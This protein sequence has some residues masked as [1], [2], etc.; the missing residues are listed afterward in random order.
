[1]L[2]GILKVEMYLPA[3]L[4][5]KEKRFVLK[6]LKTRIR[7]TF[8]VSVAEV[9]FQ[10][11]WQR[12]SLGIACVSNDRRFLDKTLANVLNTILKENRIEVLNQE[13]EIF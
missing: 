13:M 11:K 6:G 2:V 7:N 10:D 3:T 5:L 12:S 4:S 9:G 1:M 8:N